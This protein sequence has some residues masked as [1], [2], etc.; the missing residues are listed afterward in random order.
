MAKDLEALQI[1]ITTETTNA[2]VAIQGLIAEL[3]FL[4]EVCNDTAEFKTFAGNLK[5]LTSRLRSMANAGTAAAKTTAEAIQKTKEM[6]AAM[7]P[8]AE[9]AEAVA[10]A[11]EE[12]ARATG[13]AAEGQ[14]ENAEKTDRNTQ[15][16]KRNAASK[17]QVA[18]EAKKTSFALKALKATMNGLGTAVGAVV[19]KVKQFLASIVRIAMYRAIR[20]ALKA[21]T[22]GFAE[23]IKNMYAWSQITGE[24]KFVE[25]M[26]R[27]ATSMQYLKNGFASMFRPLIEIGVPILDTVVDKVVDFFN[28]IQETIARLTDQPTWTK[29]IK[30]PVKY[31]EAV[32]G[33]NKALKK[34]HELMSFDELNVINTPNDRGGSGDEQDYE[35][36]FQLVETATSQSGALSNILGGV[37]KHLARVKRGFKEA[38]KADTSQAEENIARVGAALSKLWENPDVAESRERFIEKTEETVGVV[39]GAISSIVVSATSGVSGGVASAMEDLEEFNAMKLDS[40]QG[41]LVT[42]EGSVDNI[43]IGTAEIGTALE[44][45]GFQKIVEV[46]TKLTDVEVMNKLDRFSGLLADIS[47]FFTKPYRDNAEKYKNILDD[48]ADILATLLKPFEGLANL[49]ADKSK[50]WEDS[51][52]HRFIT[53]LTELRSGAHANLLDWWDEKLENLDIRIHNFSV[54]IHDIKEDIKKWWQEFV[55]AFKIQFPEIK[56][57]HLKIGT[58]QT[59]SE[60]LKFFG[61]KE[62]PTI[63]VEWYAKGGYIP[64]GTL[65]GAGEIP[66]QVEA[67]GNINGRTGVMSGA[68]ISGIRESIEASSATEA[69]LLRLLI[70][71]L[72][73]KNLT[74]APSAALGRVNAQSASMY[75]M[76]TG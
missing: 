26:D 68:E 9:A 71:T 76:V 41:N 73:R 23:G 52:L 10:D 3:Q 44:G 65:F 53:S 30:V 47:Q 72:E 63:D 21:I 61:L 74:I 13:A 4:K 57:P 42:V 43:A 67:I 2:V 19:G 15:A 33:A 5:A 69:D 60:F 46:I 12:V 48:L 34:M 38:F 35:S 27:Y 56:L 24:N 64:Q 31:G 18:K 39:S 55:D 7:Q 14:E 50:K 58:K 54:H 66:G 22:Q 36:M 45:D 29:A 59:S 16:D 6:A 11:N 8:G 75:R 49:I 32:D 1:N 20:S 25:T 37:Q 40:I 70:T 62:V 51:W 17:R 28:T